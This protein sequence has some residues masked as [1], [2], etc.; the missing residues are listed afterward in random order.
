MRRPATTLSLLAGLLLLCGSLLFLL[1]GRGD[2]EPDL[3]PQDPTTRSSESPDVPQLR[4]GDNSAASSPVDANA[5]RS[6]LGNP[7]P[8]AASDPEFER[9]LAGFRGRIVS[10]DGKP[11]GQCP[12]Q[13]WVVDPAAMLQLLAEPL[14]PAPAD[15]V[16]ELEAVQTDREGYFLLRGAEPRAYFGLVAGDGER[17]PITFQLVHRS[18]VAGEVVDLGEIRLKDSVTLSGTVVGPD[19]GPVA[20]ALVRTFDLPGPLLGLAPVERFDPAGFVIARAERGSRLGC[21]LSL[22]EWVGRRFAQL[23]LPRTVTGADGRF[24]LTGV[25]VG[26]NTLAI[27]HDGMATHINPAL[28]TKSGQNKDLGTLRLGEGEVAQGRVLD[29]FK[30][31]VAGAQVLLAP[32]STAFPLDF[33]GQPVTSDAQGRFAKPGFGSGLVTAAAR[34]TKDDPW[35]VQMPA[36][37]ATDLVLELPAT[38]AV[39]VRVASKRGA[40]LEGVRLQLQPAAAEAEMLLAGV[41]PALALERR[42]TQ[43]EPGLF[44]IEQ[45]PLGDYALSVAAKDHATAVV[46]LRLARDQELRVE[47]SGEQK[48]RI[49]VLGPQDRPIRRATV[50]VQRTVAAADNPPDPRTSGIVTRPQVLGVTDRDGRLEASVADPVTALTIS[51]THPE[52]GPTHVRATL[53]VAEIV[54][55][56]AE[57]GS[58]EGLLTEK[59]QPPKAGL[60]VVEIHSSWTE[61]RIDGPLPD[62]ERWARPDAQGRFAL[63]G[64]RPGTYY[65]VARKALDGVRSPG[66]FYEQVFKRTFGEWMDRHYVPFEVV[67]GQTATIQVDTVA[68]PKAIEGPTAHLSGIA[69]IDGR[70][71]EGMVV[72]G[73][74]SRPIRGTV[75]GAGR[76]DLGQVGVGGLQL[77]LIDPKQDQPWSSQLWGGEIEVKANQDRELQIHVLLG[78]LEGTVIGTNAQP[79]PNCEIQA[80]GQLEAVGKESLGSGWVNVQAKTDAQGRF[81]IA[82]APAGTYSLLTEFEGLGRASKSQVV[83]QAGIATSGIELRMRR[84]Y[85][86]AG[87][88]DLTPIGDQKSPWLFV[89]LAPDGPRTPDS[90]DSSAHVEADGRFRLANVIPGTYEFCLHTPQGMWLSK[91]KLRVAEADQDG[92][93]IEI[94]KHKPPEAKPAQG[95]GGAK[96]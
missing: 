77:Q 66:T 10:H 41:V 61:N 12:V 17:R 22:P 42:C 2:P 90:S 88:V 19:G 46:P 59:G 25:D 92:L 95:E 69:T 3:G 48:V 23:P 53:P 91:Q 1:L 47:L 58:V 56:M 31:P 11:E 18:P 86:V 78:S 67:S 79:V 84:T 75:D 76:F 36:S 16:L 40:Q 96:K 8:K 50:A 81:R 70:P 68:P 43:P 37:V 33:A 83:V 7:K 13:L 34:R 82:R 5:T 63:R 73:W 39:M 4:S 24:V 71:A 45:L 20:G 9:H 27:T 30:K 72:F 26:T 14:T 28:R 89:S 74:S 64:L 6:E 49:R 85:V 80:W 32:T 15:V 35:T 44:R 60:W 55:R 38:A 57:P 54:V 62:L 65:A 51:A 21:V 29:A 94:V 87:Q 52:F 93:Q